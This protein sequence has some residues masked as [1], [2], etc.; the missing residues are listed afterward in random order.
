M[1][2]TEPALNLDMMLVPVAVCEGVPLGVEERVRVALQWR[3][4]G[5]S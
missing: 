5:S 2:R 3:K 4:T 1:T